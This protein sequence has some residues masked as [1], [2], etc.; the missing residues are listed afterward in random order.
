M[1]LLANPSTL[2]QN[3]AGDPLA[4]A[5]AQVVQRVQ[6]SLVV[7]HNGHHGIG[8]GIVWA[9]GSKYGSSGSYILTNAHV[10]A[11]GRQI[12]AALAG[13]R[14]VPASPAAEDAE[15]DLALLHIETDGLPV[16]EVADS[17]RLRVG[18]L[19]LAVGHPWGQRGVV[20]AGLVSS[21][22][23][24]HTRGPRQIVEIIRS[25]AGLA[26]G[27]S[28]GPLVNADG[29]VVGINT[30]IVGG[31]Q[32]IAIPSHLAKEFVEKALNRS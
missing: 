19:V 31:D 30:M 17:R 28:G 6:D 14:E 12:R 4:E 20:T 11:H 7:L 23:K 21:L 9:E 22:S 27:N 29:A 3:A 24:A 10:V 16:I 8:A 26:P 13:G 1:N 15:I 25:D 2:D 32:G 5:C 18:Q